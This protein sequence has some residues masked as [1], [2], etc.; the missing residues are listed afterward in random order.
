MKKI[1]V[2][3][4]MAMALTVA[5][6]CSSHY[7]LGGIERTRIVVDS[8]FD[9]QPDA[10]AVAFLAPYKQKVDSV[11]GPVVGYAAHEMWAN[12]PESDLSNLL[13]D[14]LMWASADYGEKPD[15]AIYNIGGIRAAFPKGAVTVGD[16]LDVAPFENKICFLTL[17]GEKVLE[18]FAQIVERGGE[19]VSHEVRIV[20]TADF[21]LV[22][23]TIGGKAIDPK[24]SYRVTTIDYLSQGNDHL[25]ALKDHTQLN[26]PKE[27]SANTRYLIANY[28]RAMQQ[29]GKEVDAKVEG[30]IVIQ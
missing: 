4:S 30:R 21:R 28:F 5:S 26:A 1:F 22:S 18:L 10:E 3:A 25:T 6:S 12:R 2:L 27:D 7:V 13:P 29:Q 23:A 15:F 14:I 17:T 24:A 9:A 11:M 16:V 20:G 19:G 8:R